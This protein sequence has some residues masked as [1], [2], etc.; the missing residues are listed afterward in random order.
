[1][2]MWLVGATVVDGLGGEPVAGQAV[3]VEDGRITQV[4]G[5][6]PAG[7]EVLDCAGMTLVPGLI[8][9]HV[10]FGMSSNLQASV[11]RQLSVAELAADM[12]ANCAQTLD[13]GFTTVRDTGGIDN[14][15]AGVVA[16]GK[17]PGPRILHCGPVLC[18]TGGHGH[19]APEWEPTADWVHHEIPGLRAWTMLTD[20]PDAMRR[21][22][23]EAFR[24]GASFLKL[25]VTGGVVSFHDKLSDTQFTQEEIAVAVEEATARGA[26]V[27]VH[28]HN[29][30]GVRNAIAAGVKC[31]E[32]GSEIDDEVA[33]LMSEKDVALVPTLAVI[34]MVLADVATIGLP[35][36][37]AERALTVRDGM[38]NAIHA[39][40]RAGVRIG[41]GSDLIGPNQ[42][43][44]GDELVIRSKVETPMAALV[45]ATRENAEILG[46]AEEIGTI[47]VGK[48]ADIV[49]FDVSPLDDPSV[50]ADRERVTLVVQNGTV[51]K[52]T[53]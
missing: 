53:R 44:R 38:I 15:L 16:S 39:A 26:Y 41:L 24:R 50:F 46:L 1:M 11:T 9:A 21:N 13:A 20:G 18:Q 43:N 34:D 35:A 3:L 2:P 14:G 40:R 31:V 8:D 17:I 4:G 47:E 51:V 42:R 28:A 25:C 48:R 23:R 19:L 22:A 36:H 5:H 49:G 52:D 10:H 27:T 29:N 45:S 30:A 37:I 6:V 32:H 7:A 33:A 12:F